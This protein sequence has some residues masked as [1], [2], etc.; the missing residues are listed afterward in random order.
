ML[1]RERFIKG[2]IYPRLEARV[3]RM[4]EEDFP[5]QRK[6]THN[7]KVD[8]AL[9]WEANK[10][11]TINNIQFLGVQ[12]RPDFKVH[13]GGIRVAIEVKLGQTG[14]AVREGIGQSLV[15]ANSTDFDFVLYLFV[16]TSRDK[17]VLHAYGRPIEQA[18][19]KSLWSNYN[20]RFSVI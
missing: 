6:A 8:K 18:F 15:Y 20:I 12:H 3:R 5:D 7:R 11:T 9:F 10:Q 13:Y 14:Q 4:V 19:V 2:Q 16:D 17:K 1:S